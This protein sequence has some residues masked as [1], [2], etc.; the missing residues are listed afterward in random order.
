MSWMPHSIVAPFLLDPKVKELIRVF[1]DAGRVDDVRFVGGCVR[2]VLMNLPQTDIDIATKLVPEEVKTIFEK[3]GYSVHP[4]GI[5]HGTVTVVVQGEP[6]EITTLRRDVETDGRR[7]VIEFSTEWK[8]DAERRD[9]TF[10]ALYLDV[11]GKVYD[12]FG[13]FH[14]ARNR[15]IR[16]VGSAEQRI[17]EDYLRI[18]RLFRF[19]ATLGAV[20]DSEGLEACSFNHGGLDDIS[21]E[22]IEKEILKLFGAADPMPA[23][24]AMLMTGVFQ[25]VFGTG[26]SDFPLTVFA[27]VAKATRD[28]ITRIAALFAH[29]PAI[30]ESIIERWK[31]SN[32]IKVK[33]LGAL[34]GCVPYR[35]DDREAVV[36]T[37]YKIGMVE[38]RDRMLVSWGR[39]CGESVYEFERVLALADDIEANLPVFPLRGADILAEGV[40]PGPVIGRLLKDVENWWVV[41]GYPDVE[42]C[43]LRLKELCI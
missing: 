39:D 20:V 41:A 14:D 26:V 22:R 37:A 19:Q 21:G 30:G 35:D 17:R 43:R 33:L 9:F 7:A 24:N 29:K 6:F 36:K 2:N 27:Q 1:T 25:R 5:E 18:L 34:K 10:N 8:E 23:V 28:P 31:S 38:M 12:Y 3:A 32:E 16:F 4:T 11:D 15:E 40:P 13:G 42:A